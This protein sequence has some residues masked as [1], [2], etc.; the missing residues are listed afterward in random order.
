MLDGFRP[1]GTGVHQASRSVDRHR[2]DRRHILSSPQF[3]WR[4]KILFPR[5]SFMTHDLDIVRAR[6]YAVVPPSTPP[7]RWTGLDGYVRVTDN[8]LRLTAR[9]GLE[10]VASNTSNVPQDETASTTGREDRALADRLGTLARSVLGTNALERESH[11]ERCLAESNDPRRR[12]E[13]LIDVALWDLVGKALGLPLWS[14]LGGAR[15]VIAAYASTPVLEAVED[16]E[17]LLTDLTERGFGATKIHVWC[18]PERDLELIRYLAPRFEGRMRLMLDVEQRYS[19]D[20]AVT[21]GRELARHGALWFEAPLPDTDLEAYV[22]LREA[23]DVPVICAG[24]TVNAP[25]QLDAGLAMG[26]W[27]SLRTGPTHAGGISAARRAMALAEARG[28]N[29]ELQS[30]GYEGRKLA[31]LHLAL[32]CGNCSF[33]EMPVPLEHYEYETRC[34]PRPD[35]EGLMH[36]PKG[37]GLGL[38]MDWQK[39]ET[40]A[41]VCHD[42]TGETP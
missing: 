9:N 18:E 17:E 6:V 2:V 33:F 20:D 41:F 11:N 1:P 37:S 25:G 8:I 28:A 40:D 12:G 26:A 36:A 19:F 13:S 24:N 32:G 42:L 31:S 29:V 21:M 3:A 5:V 7:Y 22:E 38:E 27:S 10:G 34:P 23:I 16:Y 14:L 15:H 35:A 39:I 4:R 30:Y